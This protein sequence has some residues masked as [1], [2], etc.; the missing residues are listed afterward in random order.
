M[1]DNKQLDSKLVNS[2]LEINQV[3]YRMPPQIS[4]ASKVTHTIQYFQQ[5]TYNNGNTMILD[6][7]TGNAYIDAHK[8]YLR[9]VVTPSDANHGFGSGS[10][11]NLFER[12]VV[13]TKTGKELSRTENANLLM[14]NMDRFFKSDNWLNTVGRAQGH[15]QEIAT[16]QYGT[17]VPAGGK[18][19]IIPLTTFLPCFNLIGSKLVPPMIASGLRLEIRL[20]DPN[21]AFCNFNQAVL[22]PLVSYTVTQPEIHVKEYTLA[23]NFSRSIAQI[24]SSQ[25]LNLLYKEYYNTIVSTSTNQINY[26]IKKAVSK[27]LK[28]S[29]FTRDATIAVGRDQMASRPYNYEKIQSNV[30]ADYVPNQ[31][32]QLPAVASADNINEVYYY[33]LEECDKLKSWDPSSVSPGQYLGVAPTGTGDQYNGAVVNFSY[34]KSN[35]SELAGYT[36]SN[37]RAMLVN[38][39]QEGVAVPVRLDT[40]LCYLRLAKAMITNTLVLD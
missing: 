1:E 27:A 18:V 36:I 3:S 26:D 30:G 29:V 10:V 9:M 8:S 34:N 13:R 7:Q 12:V 11:G 24:A 2:L 5:S 21:V 33:A 4:I 22:T 20:A 31:P 32:L 23:D 25:G 6:F 37:S 40:F 19:F 17:V 16:N 35:T 28:L 14:K 39:T 38:L 15:T